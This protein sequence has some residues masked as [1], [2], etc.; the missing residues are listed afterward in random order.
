MDHG[1]RAIRNRDWLKS[2]DGAGYTSF[3]ILEKIALDYLYLLPIGCQKNNSII[4]VNCQNV[5]K[6]QLYMY[7]RYQMC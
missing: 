1:G 2:G 7:S 5:V 6:C 3:F 4:T